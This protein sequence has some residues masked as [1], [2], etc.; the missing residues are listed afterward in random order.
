M[1]AAEFKSR[2]QDTIMPQQLQALRACQ[3]EAE[4]MAWKL[5]HIHA[6]NTCLLD[7]EG[8]PQEG[9]YNLFT[10]TVNRR[11]SQLQNRVLAQNS[12]IEVDIQ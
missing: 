9:G 1:L 12:K 5:E 7:G 8:E 3:N 4:C 11:L 10:A 6:L 2:I